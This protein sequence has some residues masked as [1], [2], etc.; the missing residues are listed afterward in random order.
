MK[1]IIEKVFVW[2]LVV[3]TALYF[4]YAVLLQLA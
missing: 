2:Y 4:L 1:R 3:M